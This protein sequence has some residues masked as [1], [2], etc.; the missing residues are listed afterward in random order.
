VGF[1]RRLRGRTVASDAKTVALKHGRLT[2]MFKLGPR[3][4]A[5]ALIRV[6]AKLDYELAVTSTLHRPVPRPKSTR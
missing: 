5:L 6:S 1:I 4:A 2:V 3:T